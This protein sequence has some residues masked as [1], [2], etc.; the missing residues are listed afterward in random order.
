MDPQ[1]DVVEDDFAVV[2]AA[3]TGS[4]DEDAIVPIVAPTEPVVRALVEAETS[5]SEAASTGFFLVDAVCGV[6]GCPSLESTF[7]S[8]PTLGGTVDLLGSKYSVDDGRVEVIEEESSNL[9]LF[10][11]VIVEISVLGNTVGSVVV[12]VT[13]GVQKEVAVV[14]AGVAPLP[15]LSPK[16][17]STRA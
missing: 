16:R 10:V 8:G 11:V 6:L 12:V 14:A 17:E 2:V 15:V 5:F 4:A 1:V 13:S 3:A 7:A 9:L